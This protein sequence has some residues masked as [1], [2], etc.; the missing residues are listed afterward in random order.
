MGVFAEACENFEKCQEFLIGIARADGL[1][2]LNWVAC[3]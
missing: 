3:T 2:K 1:V